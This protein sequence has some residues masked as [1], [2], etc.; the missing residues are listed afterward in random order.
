[1]RYLES[2]KLLLKPIEEEDILR[3]LELRWE[4]DTMQYLVH[5]PISKNKQFEWYKG[6]SDT[7]V[8]L[9]IFLKN[10]NKTELVGTIGLYGINWRHQLANWR[11]RLSPSVWGKGIAYESS[12][13]L[14]DY[15]FNTLNLRK[16]CS[17][18]FADNK[19]VVKLLHKL[20]GKEEGLLRQHFYLNGEFRDIISWGILKSDYLSRKV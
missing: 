15:A 14:M 3:L 7:D 11:I 19:A 8:A 12:N 20:G 5:E 18:S 16:I 9:T 10:D 13:M 4:K 17:T 1:M 6:L 2:S